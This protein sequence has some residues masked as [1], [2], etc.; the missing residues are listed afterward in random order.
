MANL[1]E[2]QLRARA[3]ALLSEG[4]VEVFLGYRQGSN[5]LRVAPF[6]ARTP[7]EAD[8]L[9]WNAVCVPNLAGALQKHAGRRVGVA[10]KACDARTVVELLRLH[11]LERERLHIVGVV[12]AGMGDLLGVGH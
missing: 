3:R 1:I 5:P 7:A 6:A 12:C 11:Q 10:L 9:V 8:R 2:A 4:A